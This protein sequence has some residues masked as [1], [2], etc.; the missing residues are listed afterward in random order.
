MRFQSNLECPD[1]SH[2]F[3]LLSI[4]RPWSFGHDVPSDPDFEPECTFFTHDEA[5]ILF[6]IAKQ[7][8]GTWVD[9]GSRLG[10]T[11]AHLMAA[12]CSVMAVDPEYKQP[13]FFKRFQQNIR[14]LSGF[15]MPYSQTSSEFIAYK[16]D[17][18]FDGFVIDGNHDAPE[19]LNDARGCLSLAKPDCVMVFHD[20]KGQPIRDAVEFLVSEGFSVKEYVTPNG[21]AVCW[22][23]C[24]GFVAPV[25][26]PDPAVR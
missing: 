4:T 24:S 21:V 16:S 18:K 3:K 1:L 19:P 20:L 12:G 5:A 2:N 13:K 11:A 15:C 23:G 26:V 10:W 9:I 6:C 22:R 8:R 14:G 7:I 25:H 17:S